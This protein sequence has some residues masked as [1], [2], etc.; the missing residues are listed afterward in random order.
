MKTLLI[1]EDEPELL[2][3]LSQNLAAP[4][5]RLLTAANVAEALLLLRYHSPDVIVSDIVMPKIT[6]LEF[7]ETYRTEGGL[8]RVIFF[9]A[10]GTVEYTQRAA[11]A[12]A[13]DFIEKPDFKSLREVVSIALSLPADEAPEKSAAQLRDLV[14]MLG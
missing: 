12:G 7:V 14:R 10:Y 5:R 9:S 6:G 2:E 13:F 8:A 3:L 4:D 11:C 1:L